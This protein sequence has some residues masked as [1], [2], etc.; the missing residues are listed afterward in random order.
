LPGLLLDRSMAPRSLRK[1][2]IFP[3]Q[4]FGIGVA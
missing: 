3:L 1:F 2:G 4:V